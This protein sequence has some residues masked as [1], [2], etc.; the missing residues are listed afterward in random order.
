MVAV[1]DGQPRAGTFWCNVGSKW[2]LYLQ[3]G[4]M[5]QSIGRKSEITVEDANG[6]VQY[7]I[8][9]QN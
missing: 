8:Y 2:T 7:C 5:M 6:M 9:W 1:G 4:G 3:I